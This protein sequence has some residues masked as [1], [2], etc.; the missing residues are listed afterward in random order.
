MKKPF[1]ATIIIF[2]L[3]VPLSLFSQ[4]RDFMPHITNIQIEAR[5]NLVRLTWTDSPDARGNVYIFRAARPFTGAIPANIRPIIV[6]YGQQYFIDDTDGMD[7]VHYFIAASDLTGQRFD[8]IL[9]RINSIS[10]GF[11]QTPQIDVPI[12]VAPPVVRELPRGISNL[13]AVLEGDR[14]VIT[15]DVS[16]PH[17]NV[18]LYRSMQPV[19]RPQDLRSAVIVQSGIRPPFID[20]PVS[21]I[22]WYYVALFQDEIA[23]GNITIIPGVNATVTSVMIPS[24]LE[25]E[26]YLRP[27][28]LPVLTLRNIMPE[29]FFADTH[30]KMPL[31]ADTIAIL[32]Q[33]DM[34]QR[35]PLEKL[36]PRVFA[37]DLEA[38]AGGEESI[39]FQIIMEHF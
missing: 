12:V 23:A 19:H 8:L 13:R 24:A 18:V 21:G 35:K 10:I 1:F 11:A 16:E 32:R 2:L 26:P 4:V 3:A 29:G 7:N 5:Q 22:N 27:M 6:R 30:E 17:R 37:A 15:Y 36:E 31:R 33:F 20:M 14:V 28:P 38:P 34:P 25:S 39:L 9:P